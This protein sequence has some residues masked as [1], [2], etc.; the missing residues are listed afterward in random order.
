MGESEPTK[1]KSKKFEDI[2]AHA[3]YR[4]GLFVARHPKAVLWFAII[5]TI[6]S[7]PGFY[8][9][10]KTEFERQI[11]FGKIPNENIDN[12]NQLHRFARDLEEHEAGG[13]VTTTP[14]PV[15]AKGGVYTDILRFYI[16]HKDFENLLNSATLAELYNYTEQMMK[17]KLDLNG[18]TYTLEDFCKKDNPAAKCNNLLNV[19]LKHAANLF[20]GGNSRSN[21]NLQLSYPVMY[22]FN[23]PKDIGNIIYGVD[24]KGEKNEISGAKVLTIHWFVEFPS[25]S[26]LISAFYEYRQ[27]LNKFWT[28][29]GEKSKLDFIPHNEKAMDD[30]LRL[31][32]QTA[33]PFAIPAV[34]QLML[35]VYFSNKSTDPKMSKCA[36]AVLGVV[37][38]ICALIVT[39]GFSFACG[40]AF[41]PV[42][43]TM[44]FLLLAIGI[45]DDFLI[46]GA[47]R[48]S[49]PNHS[50]AKRMAWTM[51]D[52]GASITV[53]SLT[54]FGCFALGYVLSPTPAV[55]DFCLVTAIGMFFD[56]I[57]QITFFCALVV[58]G[59]E[60]EEYGGLSSY[61]WCGTKPPTDKD[62]VE[63]PALEAARG[64]NE[65]NLEN[66]NDDD[67][68]NNNNTVTRKGFSAKQNDSD[69]EDSEIASHSANEGLNKKPM[70]M[71]KQLGEVWAPF[72]LRKDV[73]LISAL[74]FVLYIVVSLYGCVKMKVDISPK[75]YIRDSSTMQTFVHLADKYIWADN[76]QPLFHV[77][78]PP[79]FRNATQ[80]NKFNEL[81]FRLEHTK[82]SIGRV[83]TNFWLWQYQ[84]FL[85]DFPE[86]D[87]Q[88]DFYNR[89]YL[90][91]FLNT[92]D[93]AEY[94]AK[95]R[96]DANVTN[97]EPCISAFHFATSFYGLDSWDKRQAELFFWRDMLKE[98]QEF[99]IFL[100]GI[101]S[102]FLIDQRF[103]I[104][105][106]SMQSFG[107]AVAVMALLSI[108]FLPDKQSAFIIAFSIMS[109]TLG[110]CGFLQMWGSDLDS[111][112][113]GCL[114]MSIGLSIDFSV[115]I[116]YKYHRS[117]ELTPDLKVIDTLTIVGYPILQAIVS[118]LWSM[119]AVYF[120]PA[121]LV[122]VFF[123]TVVLVNVFGCFH[124]LLWLPQFISILDPVNRVPLRF[125]QD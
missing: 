107:S 62:I 59:A 108:L 34:L 53:T 122:R 49:N 118:T 6:A 9:P 68:E 52:A 35:F 29:T 38:V 86:V 82:Y 78:N 23:R 88:K 121:Y 54:N 73:K 17:V 33:L 94:K 75:K 50:I 24:V 31:I 99:D 11:A 32:I 2:F 83:S 80:R 104:A 37:C 89:K 85:N 79:D 14:A 55:G 65:I 41:N 124:A 28:E 95:I 22:L 47:W 8:A 1:K 102:P 13:N 111:V 44:P 72:I 26:T 20:K 57:Y 15:K 66:N 76:V 16:V 39:F 119:S 109:I 100:A 120:I 87:Y 21:P 48:M 97:G 74:L 58:L 36:E 91:L 43:C 5:L 45:D 69:D 117:T 25:N 12:W 10:V 51:E 115:H 56:Y 98:Y 70:W 4:W 101:F 125:K 7:L 103:T 40:I 116:C 30:E 84:Q 93:Y 112:S 113:L 64:T 110:V 77:M 123:Q 114:I 90:S 105:P 42:T 63:S 92:M 71:T 19:W 96:I 60:R 67:N 106:S 3:F 61:F 18:Y 81:I 27:E 46:L